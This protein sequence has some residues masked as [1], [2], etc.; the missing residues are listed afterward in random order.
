MKMCLMKDLIPKFLREYIKLSILRHRY[1]GR[2]IYSH[3]ISRDVTLGTPC[4]VHRDVEIGSAVA[5]GNHSYVNAG[6]IIISGRIGKFCSIGYSCQIG[7]PEHPVDFVSTSPF[8]YGE[9]NLFRTDAFYS[10]VSSPPIIGNDVWI[11]SKAVILQG[12]HIGDGTIIAAGAVVTK[13]VPSFSI[14]GGM[15]AR[16]IRMRFDEK[17]VEYLTRLK[18]WDLPMEELL[19]MK[20]VF[21]AGKDWDRMI[22]LD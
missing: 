9:V 18:W 10:G 2:R 4:T 20:D 3:L 5:I 14:V 11:G 17:K 16:V 7:L 8:T 6:T 1:P 19:K 12:V 15:P 21:M 13:D 22:S